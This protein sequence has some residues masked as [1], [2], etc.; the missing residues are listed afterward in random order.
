MSLVQQLVALESNIFGG[1]AFSVFQRQAIKLG[2]ASQID[3]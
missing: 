2:L 1:S 3:D